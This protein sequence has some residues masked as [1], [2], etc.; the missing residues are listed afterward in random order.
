MKVITHRVGN[1]INGE[2]MFLSQQELQLT[3]QICE[4]LKDF[5]L[6]SLKSEETY[7]FYSDSYLSN[8]EVFSSVSSIFENPDTF[9]FESESIARTLFNAAENPRIQGGEL[10]VVLFEGEKP[11]NN[12]IGIFKTEKRESILKFT[13][14]NDILDIEKDQGVSLNKIDKAALIYNTGKETGYVLSAIDN[15]KNGD[16]FYWFEDFLHIKQREDNYYHT[17]ELLMVFKDFVTK[18]LTQEYEATK[19]DQ[20]NFLKSSLTYFMEKE[21]FAFE[22]FTNEVLVD[23]A[24]IQSFV[25]F[26]TDY[27]QDYQMNISEE[28]EI[29]TAAV[30]KVKRHFKSVIKLDKNFQIHIHGDKKLLEQGEDEKGKFYQLYFQKEQ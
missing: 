5:F 17:N 4:E 16:M 19:V 24:V 3:E 23:Q 14:N 13:Y 11:E 9:L 7:Q 27:E 6:G 2:G 1:K 25:D 30:K 28:F 10:F 12:Q 18:Q 26:K 8:N 15:S 29:N 21:N 20:V 22:E